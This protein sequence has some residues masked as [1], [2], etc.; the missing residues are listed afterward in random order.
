MSV[1]CFLA[2]D[3]IADRFPTELARPHITGQDDD[4]VR[5]VNHLAVTIGQDTI[6][7]DLEQDI[8]DVRMSLLNL[9]E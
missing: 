1:G 3:S 6:L 8:K 7:Q 2:R 9:I 5:E 4:T